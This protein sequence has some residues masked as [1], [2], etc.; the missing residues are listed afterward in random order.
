MVTDFP[1]AEFRLTGDP[2]AIR[3][4]ASRWSTFGQGASDAATQIRS[5]DTSLF[6][7]PEGDQYREGLNDKLPPHLDT[8]GSAYNKV[9]DALNTFAD[10]LSHLQDRMRPLTANAPSLWD[11]V[12]A[13]QGR[14]S[15]AKAADNQH[16][17]QLEAAAATRP[18]DQ[19]APPDTYQPGTSATSASLSHAQQQWNDCLNAA[20]QV[21][22]DHHAAVEKC[23]NAI[24][25]AAEMR[26]AHNPS[27][28]GS[29][30]ENVDSWIKDHVAELAKLSGFLKTISV[31]TGVLSFLPGMGLISIITGGTALAI[32]TSIA[33]ATGG[34]L[35][36]VLIE[37]ATM[38]IPFGVGKLLG[39]FGAKA[40]VQS[41]ARDVKDVRLRVA[42]TPEGITAIARDGKTAGQILMDARSAAAEARSVAK[43]TFGTGKGTHTAKVTIERNG[44]TVASGTEV[45]GNMTPEEA[46]LGFPKSTL[47]THTEARAVRNHDLRPG[48]VMKIEG[49]YP[50]C[51]PCKGAMSNAARTNGATVTYTWP[52]GEWTTG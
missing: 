33:L 48:D 30:M 5:L 35:T 40:F 24:R 8:T 42:T 29:M 20:N 16:Q 17:Q 21:T 39:K 36:S 38:A 23:E 44:E 11:A 19:P 49:Q 3:S 2:V 9:A 37:G 51:P 52:G 15:S 45:S 50:P 28:F 27:W 41:V 7:G 47:A 25:D 43:T 26:F 32:D 4:S 6:I 1:A 14:V 18:A 22:A 34:D 13:A 12:Q 31:I 46:A 10:A